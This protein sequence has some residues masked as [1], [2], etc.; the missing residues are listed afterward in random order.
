[1]GGPA[2]HTIHLAVSAYGPKGVELESP[3]RRVDVVRS[4]G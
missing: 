4:T 1:M 2:P 3:S